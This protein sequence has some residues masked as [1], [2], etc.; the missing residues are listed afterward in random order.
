MKYQEEFQK[1]FDS[2]NKKI[3]EK[4]GAESVAYVFGSIG[5]WEYCEKVLSSKIEEL[6]NKNKQYEEALKNI[7]NVDES[8]TIERALAIDALEGKPNVV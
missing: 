2:Q 4:S 5:A 7:A 1:W 3:Y 8:V 6:E